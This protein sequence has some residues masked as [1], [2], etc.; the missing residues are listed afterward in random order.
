MP[1]SEVRI[2]VLL[3]DDETVIREGLR[4]LI[5]SWPTL[6]VIGEADSPAEALMIMAGSKPNVIV[7]CH[8]R[9]SGS[10]LEGLRAVVEAADDIPVVVLASQR[11]H[12]AATSALTAGANCIISKKSTAADLREA[13]EYLH[14]AKTVQSPKVRSAS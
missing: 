2:R 5:D 11:Y 10:F 3:V 13:L 14:F 9:N 7:C 4:L 6:E 1:D 8:E 12:Q